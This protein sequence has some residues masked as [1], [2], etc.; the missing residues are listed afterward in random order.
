MAELTENQAR[1]GQFWLVD[2]VVG[3]LVLLGAAALVLAWKAEV[4]MS[5]PAAAVANVPA[6]DAAP[7]TAGVDPTAGWISKAVVMAAVN[8]VA[9]PVGTGLPNVKTI[10]IEPTQI[11]AVLVRLDVVGIDNP[12]WDGLSVQAQQA[13]ADH[14]ASSIRAALPELALPTGHSTAYVRVGIWG[15]HRVTDTTE[16]LAERYCRTRELSKVANYWECYLPEVVGMEEVG[17]A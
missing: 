10:Q 7:R 14:V 1:S 4:R 16:D 2:L 8:R 3:A 11:F 9:A 6:A 15:W 17:G 5:Q 13:Y 12:A